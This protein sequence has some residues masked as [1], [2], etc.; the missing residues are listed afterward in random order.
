M[1][2]ASQKVY[3]VGGGVNPTMAEPFDTW[4][5]AHT[6]LNE[7]ET[8]LIGGCEVELGEGEFVVTNH[9]VLSQCVQYHGR[10][11]DRTIVRCAN[12]RA[13][14]LN[15]ERALVENLT[16]TNGNGR[17]YSGSGYEEP[18]LGICIGSSGGT[19]RGCR[20][21]GSKSS[22]LYQRGSLAVTGSK[23]H[24]SHCIIDHNTAT[25]GADSYAGLFVSHG[26]ADNCLVYS[27][28]ST[29]AGG[30]AIHGNADAMVSNC[31]F[32]ANTATTT[33]S[34]GLRYVFMSY[35]P[36][37][38][39]VNCIFAGNVGCARA[40]TPTGGGQFDINELDFIWSGGYHWGDNQVAADKIRGV[41]KHCC[42][43]LVD[44]DAALGTDGLNADPRFANASA[45]DYRLVETPRAE[46]SPCVDAGLYAP[47]MN[48]ATDLDGN[49]RVKHV[50]RGKGRVDIGCY[51]SAYWPLGFM[52]I[53]R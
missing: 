45:C 30:L 52:L 9:L 8:Y 23:G 27:N 1:R 20:V 46:R 37:H 38:D 31:T 51:E 33:S 26:H 35:S 12:C 49:V 34:G 44:E 50:L 17:P 41:L 3:A 47:W 43:N 5:K 6:N 2:L 42:F 28:V 39:I 21:T 36:S 7:L 53:V 24:A 22:S 19:V 18:G 13:F 14:Y 25:S 32:T 10:G 11:I 40:T 48:D 29:S 15:N 4:E 16:V